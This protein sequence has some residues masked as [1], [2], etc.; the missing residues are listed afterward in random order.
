MIYIASPFFNEEQ[1]QVV[2]N[3]EYALASAGY[4]FFSPRKEAVT[5]KDLSPEERERLAKEV[6][7]SNIKG[8]NGSNIMIA[9][10]DDFDPGTMFEIGYFAKDMELYNKYIVTLSTKGYGANVMISQC[11][12]GHAN[13]IDDAVK[14]ISNIQSGKYERENSLTT[15]I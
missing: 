3:I 8:M 9:V 13:S 1:L 6:Y 12:D 10:I 14:I 15:V 11:S 4:E 7:E 2:E 5:L